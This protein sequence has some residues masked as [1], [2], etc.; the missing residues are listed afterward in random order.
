MKRR[1]FTKLVSL[2]AVAISTTGFAKFNQTTNSYMGDCQTTSDILG[3]FYRPNSPVRNNL[4]IQ[5]S[6]GAIVELSGIVRHKD[7]QNPYKNAKV[8]LWHC[9]ADE[10]YDNE[11]NEFRYRGTTFC[12]K[13][14]AYKFTTQMPVPYDAGGGYIRPAHFHL[15]ISAPGYQSL[16][17]QIYFTGDAYLEKDSSSSVSEAKNRILKVEEKNGI[18]KVVFDCSM[19]DQLRASYDALGKILGKYKNDVSGNELE[20]FESDGLLWRKNEVFGESFNYIGNNIFEYGGVPG[21]AYQHLH[22]DLKQNGQV[23]LTIK[24]KNSGNE[25]SSTFTKV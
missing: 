6:S 1:D 22:F 15:M 10:I 11:T 14:G 4:V 13:D 12:D 17:T 20:L 25:R 18:K 5:N 21:D 3:P 19:N 7:C 2:S 9:S 8:E 23:K 24:S 16:I